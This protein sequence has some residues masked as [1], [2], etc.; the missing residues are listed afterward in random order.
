MLFFHTAA[1][2]LHPYTKTVAGARCRREQDKY[3]LRRG[4]WSWRRVDATL[5]DVVEARLAIE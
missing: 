1:N 2:L 3:D 5:R 4:T